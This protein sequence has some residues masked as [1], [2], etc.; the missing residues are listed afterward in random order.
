M[1]SWN[2]FGNGEEETK[3]RLCKQIGLRPFSKDA[4]GPATGNPDVSQYDLM[5]SPNVMLR[6]AH[7]AQIWLRATTSPFCDP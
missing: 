4:S 2:L 1:G 7:L 5:L 3:G 6:E